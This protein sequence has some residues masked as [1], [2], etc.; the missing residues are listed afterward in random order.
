MW[1]N[2]AGSV[3]VE[4]NKLLLFSWAL[5]PGIGCQHRVTDAV[6]L[7]EQIAPFGG[8]MDATAARILPRV[9]HAQL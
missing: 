8:R 1:S 9:D 6:K 3:T 4:G 5:S 7:N 2:E